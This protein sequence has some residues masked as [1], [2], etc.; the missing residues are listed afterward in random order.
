M[1]RVMT[2]DQLYSFCLKNNFLQFNS[3][4]FGKELVVEMPGHFVKSENETNKLTEGLV[5]FVSKAF[6]DHVN[7]NSSS[8]KEEDFRKN[9]PSSNFRPVLA[10]II[11]DE[12]TNE[13]DFGSHDF[14]IET[15]I[16]N[17][18]NGNEIKIDK[19]V[20]DE[21]PIGVIDGSQTTIE[22]D[23]DAKVNRAVLHGY[24]YQEYCPDAIEILERRG[25]VDCSVELFIRDLSMDANQGVLVLND[26]YVSGL[27]LLSAKC[28]PGMA[29][30]NFKIEDFSVIN[31]NSIIEEL[32]NKIEKLENAIYCK[33]NNFTEGGNGKTMNY[34]EELL[35]KYNKKVED[36]TFEYENL[37]N[38]ELDAKFIEAFGEVNE[39]SETSEV[40]EDNA[41]GTKKKKK[42]CEEDE[43]NSEENSEDEQDNE[44]E[45]KEDNACGTKK[46][47]KQCSIENTIKIDDTV[48]K[49][50][51]SLDDKIC[52]IHSL[53]NEIYSEADNTYYGTEVYETYVI[54]ID[55]YH[56]KYY[57]QSYK[58]E[59]DVYTLV[60]DRVEVFAEYVTAE[61]QEEL[62]NMRANY[63]LVVDELNKY[64]Y[65]EQFAEK[66]NVFE[67]ESYASYLETDEFKAL[68][69]KET[70]DKF[71][72]EELAEK[73][74]AALGRLVKN[75]KTFEYN[76][77]QS[78][79]KMNS[80]KVF[81]NVNS[82]KKTSRYGDI[83]K[84]K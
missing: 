62:K 77:N 44:I 67:D 6:H 36:I 68:M 10:N 28:K 51:V 4:D 71:T 72:K 19:V 41:C 21:Q 42:Q 14:H 2:I 50:E 22:Y 43:I 40:K 11:K 18:E 54:M 24:L 30:S 69:S 45:V 34:F 76:E 56:G 29:G 52:S 83:F 66:M 60:G 46:K 74:D 48:K 1:S 57:K 3:K 15:V 20:Y 70:V 25:T 9:V 49:Y 8:I 63:S 5:P 61:E 82:S 17:D 39:S 7:L 78:K 33:L 65:D 55:Y 37:S 47:K 26:F 38:E 23:E 80:V 13:L 73:A 58:D 35:V 79:K 16:K 31:T 32:Q 53:V 84:K 12:E 64:K 59:N 75:S 81:S 27:T